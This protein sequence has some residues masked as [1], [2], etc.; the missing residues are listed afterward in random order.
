VASLKGAEAPRFA[1]DQLTWLAYLGLAAYAFYIY[2][3][4]PVVA[5][6]HHELHLSYTLTS[7]HA[8][9][10]S[11]GAVVAGLSFHRLV[12]GL[13]RHRLFRLSVVTTAVGML[14][15]VVGHAVA[16]TLLAA[17]VLGTG[18]SVVG[19]VSSVVLADH[20]GRQRDRALVEANL[21]ASG[22][23][24][25]VPALLGLLALTA[26]GW[27]PAMVLPVLVLG[28]LAVLP[29]RVPLSPPSV[30]T[31]EAG[32]LP[33][34]FWASCLL[35][36]LMVGIEYCILFYGVPLLGISARISTADAAATLS[37]FVGG[38]FTGRLAG[39]WLTRRPGR[40][41]RLIGAALA[42]ALAGFLVLWLARV[43]VLAVVGL[44]ITG[45]GIGNLYPL[46]LALAL[47]AAGGRTDQA[48][49]RIQ[50]A[51]GVAIGTAPLLLGILSDHVGVIRALA[52][53]PG[54]I[55]AAALVLYVIRTGRGEPAA[56]AAA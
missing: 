53:E 8:T 38:E 11:V 31:A 23:G 54:L 32:R 21:G 15:F 5:F 34:G 56:A 44:F 19:A 14:L 30:S 28:T 3:L 29:V 51:V 40:S 13:G 27:R 47:G 43:T 9:L 52:V 1:R 36:A 16:V 17:L 4:G 26:G 49:S 25:L 33:R 37:L 41:V 46:S 6:L 24:V 48:M 45:L 42:V 18:A 2:A 10:W 35:V 20:H 12:R 55:V 39:A 50:A 7:L 22:V